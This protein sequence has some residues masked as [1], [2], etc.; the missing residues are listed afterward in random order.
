MEPQKNFYLS[1]LKEQIRCE[2][3]DDEARLTQNPTEWRVL[4]DIREDL[5]ADLL[6]KFQEQWENVCD[7]TTPTSETTLQL[8]RISL[9]LILSILSSR[10]ATVRTCVLSWSRQLERKTSQASKEL[11]KLTTTLT[12]L[13]AKLE[14]MKG[15]KEALDKE[16]EAKRLE[17]CHHMEFLAVAKTNTKLQ[18]ESQLEFERA[19]AQKNHEQQTSIIKVL[20]AEL[21]TVKGAKAALQIDMKALRKQTEEAKKTLKRSQTSSLTDGASESREQSTSSSLEKGRGAAGN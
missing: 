18:L 12:Y 9:M 16:V 2:V 5:L 3:S 6:N 13:Y 17:A 14:Q 20:Q 8:E 21:E 4:L 11:Q 10:Q 7:L 19:L 15:E 1:S